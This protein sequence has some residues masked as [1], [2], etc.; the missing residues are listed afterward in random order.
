MTEIQNVTAPATSPNEFSSL[1][2]DDLRLR[3]QHARVEIPLKNQLRTNSSAG[4]FQIH[5]PVDA[6]HV[7][8]AGCHLLQKRPAAVDV[9]NRRHGFPYDRGED[10]LLVGQSELAVVLRREFSSP[11][12]EQLNDLRAGFDLCVQIQN[13]R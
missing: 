5:P 6:Q 9:D 11:R 7:R 4:V 8:A 3:K 1:L 12:V 2:G 13:D 10:L